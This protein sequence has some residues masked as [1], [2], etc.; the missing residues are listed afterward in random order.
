MSSSRERDRRP[1]EGASEALAKARAPF[2][3][4]T[5]RVLQSWGGLKWRWRSMGW[6]VLDVGH[7]PFNVSARH[8]RLRFETAYGG[9]R[10]LGYK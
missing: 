9:R 2:G 1:P 10:I 5:V 4:V 6:V 7:W 3:R 8:T